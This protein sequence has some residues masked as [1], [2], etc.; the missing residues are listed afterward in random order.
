VDIADVARRSGVPASALRFYEARGLIESTGRRGLRRLFDAGVL[1]RL[2]LIGL[3]RAA[4]FSLDEIGV[5][6]GR[7]G[8]PTIDRIALAAKADAL[9]ATIGRLLGLRDALRH[10]AACPAPSHFE[11]PTFQRLMKQ[12]AK[13]KK[14][15]SRKPPIIG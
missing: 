1:D 3:G 9:D 13:A 11:C 12:T 4:G 2:A 7:R 14:K 8:R 10:A 15:V 6:L 5:M